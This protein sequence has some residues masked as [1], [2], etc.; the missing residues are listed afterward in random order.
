M[1]LWRGG[2]N[3]AMERRM[4]WRMIAVVSQCSVG[5]NQSMRVLGGMGQTNSSRLPNNSYEIF[6]VK[7]KR[8]TPL[9][10]LIY[11]TWSGVYLLSFK[12]YISCELFGRRKN[13]VLWIN[14]DVKIFGHFSLI[15]IMMESHIFETVVP[16]IILI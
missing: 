6:T 8:Y 15:S 13:Y 14:S 10:A 1:E 16:S 3:E 4:K 9:Y 11:N 5:W 7:I 2:W 12:I